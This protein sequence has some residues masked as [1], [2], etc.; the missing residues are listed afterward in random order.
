MAKILVVDDEPA[1]REML[2]IIL[3]G[4]GYDVK[5]AAHGGQAQRILLEGWYPDVVLL[6]LLMPEVN[7]YQLY[8]WLQRTIPAA[9]QP[10]VVIVTASNITSLPRALNGVSH[11]L[12]KPF[13]LVTMLDLLQRLTEQVTTSPTRIAIAS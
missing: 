13:S 9:R 8:D 2:E 12:I 3:T 1:L 6:D 5:I 4:E 7:G 11:M 10:A